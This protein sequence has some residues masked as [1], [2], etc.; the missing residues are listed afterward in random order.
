MPSSR[1]PVVGVFFKITE[2][3]Y[4]IEEVKVIVEREEPE[5]AHLLFPVPWKEN[6]QTFMRLQA[7]VDYFRLIQLA[8]QKVAMEVCTETIVDGWDFIFC[9]TLTNEKRIYEGKKKITVKSVRFGVV[10]SLVNSIR[11]TVIDFDYS[12]LFKCFKGERIWDFHFTAIA[13]KGLEEIFE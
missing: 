8:L 13:T 12:F 6:R 7:L 11:I 1:V 4:E 9:G 10:P 5:R 2:V 3:A